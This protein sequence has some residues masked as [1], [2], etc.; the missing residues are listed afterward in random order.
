MRNAAPVAALLAILSGPLVIAL[1]QDQKAKP[2]FCSKAALA[3]LRPL[4]KLKYRC[5]SSDDSDEKVLKQP[6]RQK[7]SRCSRSAGAPI[8]LAPKWRSP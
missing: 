7:A 8:A 6:A 5:T 4:P 3:A 2:P 1:S